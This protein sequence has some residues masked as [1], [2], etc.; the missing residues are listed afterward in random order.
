MAAGSVH[1]SLAQAGG[2]VKGRKLPPLSA[3]APAPRSGNK[4]ALA[5]PI[6]ALELARARD[7]ERPSA[8]GLLRRNAATFGCG[9]LRKPRICAE[10][11]R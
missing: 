7:S 5:Q 6:S 2:C 3:A 10:N 9:S 1:P 11:E 8:R 4:R